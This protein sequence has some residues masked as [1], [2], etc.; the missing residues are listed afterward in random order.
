[1]KPSLQSEIT[2]IGFPKCGT[3]ALLNKYSENT[4][5]HLLYYSKQQ[6]Y[7]MIWPRIKELNAKVDERKIITHKYAHYIYNLE[8]LSFLTHKNPNSIFVVLVRNPLKSL[9]SWHNMH[10]R[11]ATSQLPRKHAAY[12]DKKFYANCSIEQYYNRHSN[13]LQYDI[14]LN[15]AISI[16][17]K[18]RIVVVSQEKMSSA[19]DYVAEYTANLARGEL[20]KLQPDLYTSESAK[21]IGFADTAC[22]DLSKSII[23]ELEGISNRTKIIVDHNF[24][25]KIY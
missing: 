10:R 11:I 9:I 20:N 8:A 15:N 7:E 24:T 14:H 22:I 23:E 1:M 18:E 16:I 25:H 12:R 21:H 13:L 2:I 6:K 17:P 5:F 3:T 4:D 19:V